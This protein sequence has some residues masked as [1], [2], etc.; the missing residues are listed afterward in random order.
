MNSKSEERQ[1]KDASKEAHKKTKTFV[2]EVSKNIMAAFENLR[3][4]VDDENIFT[5][6]PCKKGLKEYYEKHLKDGIDLDYKTVSSRLNVARMIHDFKREGIL[7]PENSEYTPLRTLTSAFC[8]NDNKRKLQIMAWKIAEQ[9]YKNPDNEDIIEAIERVKSKLLA[10]N[11]VETSDDDYEELDNGDDDYAKSKNLTPESSAIKEQNKLIKESADYEELAA[12][13]FD[14]L[15]KEFKNIFDKNYSNDILFEM[16]SA[17]S[18][19]SN[20]DNRDHNIIKRRA[21]KAIE[22][23]KHYVL[24][25]QDYEDDQE[26]YNNIT[27]NVYYH[28]FYKKRAKAKSIKMLKF[29]KEIRDT[30]NGK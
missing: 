11:W 20:Y 4:M 9:K 29:N 27:N 26:A 14:K 10:D 24:C 19:L 30:D 7:I 25:L 2:D 8:N 6:I 17:I 12:G 13:F 22:I 28:Y 5:K 3:V 21:N 15:P 23:L 16:L 18:D 1:L